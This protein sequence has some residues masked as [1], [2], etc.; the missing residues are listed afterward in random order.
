MFGNDKHKDDK[1]KEQVVQALCCNHNSTFE[2]LSLG[3]WHSNCF[4]WPCPL[5]AILVLS[6]CSLILATNFSC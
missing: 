4:L 1:N 6:V 5:I 2:Q 3:R